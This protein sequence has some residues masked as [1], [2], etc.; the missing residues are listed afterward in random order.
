MVYMYV[1]MA[2]S[3]YMYVNMA[4]SRCM[5]VNMAQS[6]YMYVNMAGCQREWCPHRSPGSLLPTPE[7]KGGSW[8]KVSEEKKQQ[9][10]SYAKPLPLSLWLY[11]L[12]Q[13]DKKT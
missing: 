2:Q 13:S 9:G 12:G 3:Q 1:N 4:Q 10:E 6:R 8:C 7:T 5:C 11:A